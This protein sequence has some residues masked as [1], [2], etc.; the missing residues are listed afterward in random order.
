V[1]L[2][3][4]DWFASEVVGIA[5]TGFAVTFVV[6]GS[7]AVVVVLVVVDVVM[8]VTVTTMDGAATTEPLLMFMSV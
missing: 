6:V 5:I 2:D 3:S 1:T 7:V 4:F 8:V